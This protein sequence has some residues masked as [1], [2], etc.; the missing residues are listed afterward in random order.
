VT[1]RALDSKGELAEF[2]ELTRM[3][4]ADFS[5]SDNVQDFELYL[6]RPK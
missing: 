3:L 6:R 2:P 5:Y 4:D 1:G